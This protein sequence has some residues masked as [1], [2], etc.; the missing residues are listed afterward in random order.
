AWAFAGRLLL[1][2][3]DRIWVRGALPSRSQATRPAPLRLSPVR[4]FP[5]VA[6]D[7]LVVAEC[8]ASRLAPKLSDTLLEGRIEPTPVIGK[9]LNILITK[10]L[11]QG[12][13]KTKVRQPA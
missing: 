11:R 4:I 13:G 10:G 1:R 9:K 8:P 5:S 7:I 6:S 3:P 12:S 2:K